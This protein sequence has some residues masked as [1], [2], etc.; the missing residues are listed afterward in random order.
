MFQVARCYKRLLERILLYFFQFLQRNFH[1]NPTDKNE[2]DVK[3]PFNFQTLTGVRQAEGPQPEV[4]GGVGDAA[5]AV[6]DRVD[7]LVHAHV[8]QVELQRKGR[9]LAL[10]AAAGGGKER[11]VNMRTKNGNKGKKK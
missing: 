1:L 9:E 6:L 8:R 5:E 3:F 4:G 11:K 2:D 10:A 7:R